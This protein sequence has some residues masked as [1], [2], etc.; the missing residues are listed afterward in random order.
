MLLG[1]MALGQLPSYL[2]MLRQLFS[3]ADDS[4]QHHG[5]SRLMRGLLHEYFFSVL[6]GVACL[7]VGVLVGWMAEAWRSRSFRVGLVALTA[8][9]LTSLLLTF[10]QLGTCLWPGLIYA[11]LLAAAL[12]FLNLSSE[13]RLLCV[14]AGLVLFIT[15]LG[16]GNGLYN[17][18]YAMCFA[19]PVAVAALL[20]RPEAMESKP[21]GEGVG[22]EAW[23][24]TSGP[25]SMLKWIPGFRA[26]RV[27]LFRGRIAAGLPIHTP[28]L[29]YVV[30][31]AMIASS[32]IHRWHFT[33]RDSRQRLAMRAT[34]HHPKL[35][36][37]FTTPSRARSLEELLKQLK[38]LV[39][40]NDYLLD[41]MQIP[42]IYFLT[43]T[44]PYLYS[45]WANLYDPAVFKRALER[46]IATHP[47]LPVC[48]K[49]RVDTCHPEWP[50]ETY[51]LVQS[52]RPVENR[53]LVERFLQDHS[54]QKH[55]ENNAFEIWLPPPP[56][57]VANQ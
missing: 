24:A 29:G 5:V 12:G 34:V 6:A 55:W 54:Y 20:A 31:C 45:N 27:R 3:M 38:P 36:Y 53:R 35:R 41:H 37:V 44:K 4:S 21:G 42:M 18:I 13:Y 11:I 33:Y 1:I 46:A 56:R 48:V 8:G 47:L 16:S 40:K 15:P 43:E 39:Q 32:I 22:K 10:E 49:T 9:G 51:P 26:P 7:A 50:E 2:H 19:A 23:K 30:L 28:T 14:L 25:W 57:V 52:S 17:G